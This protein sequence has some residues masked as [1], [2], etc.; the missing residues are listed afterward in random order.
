MFEETLLRFFGTFK[1]GSGYWNPV[2]WIVAFIIVFLI[3][4]ILRGRG[5]P[6]YKKG[7]LQTQV[8]LS[9]NPEYEKSD[10]H[11]KASNLYWGWVEAARWGVNL[12]KRMHTG[13]AN[14][15]ILWFT[16][17]MAI[18]FILIGVI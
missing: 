12:V 9:G 18:L 13:R 17:M 15:Y 4:Y 2:V 10:M 3:I 6:S 16:F 1:T 11:V 7:S 5:N 8:F 14:D